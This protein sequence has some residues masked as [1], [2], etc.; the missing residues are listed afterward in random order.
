MIGIVDYGMGNLLSVFHAVETLGGDPRICKHAEELMEVDR[1][2]L[3]GVGSFGRCIANLET[4]GFHQALDE[5]V[6]R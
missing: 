2:I 5:A 6:I 3:P 1:V 4:E